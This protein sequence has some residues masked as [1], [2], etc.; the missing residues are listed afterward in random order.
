VKL[1]YALP[2]WGLVANVRGT[3]LGK[4]P[5]SSDET[6]PSDFAYA[7]QI[8]NLYASKMLARGVR[9]FAA[10]D[11]LGDSRDRKLTDAQPTFDRPDYGRTARFGVQYS[12][13]RR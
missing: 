11:N 6:G 9:V 10:V 3:F 8:W 7:Y 4:W 12:F 2:A 1:E 5:T 13:T